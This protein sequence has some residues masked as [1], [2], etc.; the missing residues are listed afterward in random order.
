MFFFGRKLQQKEK[1]SEKYVHPRQ[2][3]ND[4]FN[5]DLSEG[6]IDERIEKGLSFG[7]DPEQFTSDEEDD[8]Q[9]EEIMAL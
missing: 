3:L 1:D 8:I 5:E 7:K 4:I 9:E 2:M 6:E